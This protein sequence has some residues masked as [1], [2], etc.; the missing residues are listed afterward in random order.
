[1][2][3]LTIRKLIQGSLMILI[4][5]AITFALLSSAGGDALTSLRDN[6]QIS[7]ATVQELQKIYGL[8]RPLP[9]R[10]AIWLAGALRGDLGESFSYRIPVAT[11]VGSRFVN[12]AILS[13]TA[14]VIAILVSFLLAIVGVLYPSRIIGG[15][16]EVLILLTASTPRMVLALLFLVIALRFG[17]AGPQ[18]GSLG[19]F[20]LVSGSIVLAIPLVSIFLAQLTD[21]LREAMSEDFIRMARAKGLSEWAVLTRHA[22]RA[23]LTPFLTIAGLSLGGLLGG[24][25]IVET[26]LGWPGIGALMVAAVRGRDVPLVMG[27]V[28]IASATVWLGNAIAEFLQLLNDRRLRD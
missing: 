15:L 13:V 6:P 19:L 21:A 9:E 28:L 20:Q 4:V 26:V 11:I 8:D 12:T 17:F 5:S 14:F 27:V 24:S 10:Y 2:L 18:A 7:E 23:A 1:M 25:V 22:L 3:Q 16:I